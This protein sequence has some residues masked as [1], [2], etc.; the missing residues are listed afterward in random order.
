MLPDL[1]R[2][3]EARMADAIAAKSKVVSSIQSNQSHLV[4]QY[5]SEWQHGVDM[6]SQAIEDFWSGVQVDELNA[7]TV[8]MRDAKHAYDMAVI[9]A[10]GEQPW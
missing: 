2:Q 1:L 7:K 6:C 5:V 10:S 8:K 4:A 3:A 9:E